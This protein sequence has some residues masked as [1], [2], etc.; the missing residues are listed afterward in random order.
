M[1]RPAGRRAADESNGREV[2]PSA[3][4][5]TS[6]AHRPA[7]RELAGVVIDANAP[8][9]F[10]RSCGAIVW[11]GRTAAG[12]RCPFDVVDGART[13]ITHFSTCPEAKQWTRR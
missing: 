8:K 6:A 2:V 10:C 9:T 12:K 4:S 7:G 13:A 11:W 1:T 5:T 3:P